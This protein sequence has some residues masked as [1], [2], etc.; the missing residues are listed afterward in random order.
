ME[1]VVHDAEPS[2]AAV[3]ATHVVR[4]VVAMVGHAF[5][6][7]HFAHEPASCALY[8]PIAHGTAIECVVVS[9]SVPF[10]HAIHALCFP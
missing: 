4:A 8:S 6:A 3:P 9:H 10:G 1:H 7:G 5:P 2:A